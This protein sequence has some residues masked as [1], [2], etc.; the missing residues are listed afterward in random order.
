MKNEQTLVTQFAE[1]S[2]LLEG[3]A[4]RPIEAMTLWE[5]QPAKE[6]VQAFPIGNGRLGGMVFGGIDLERIQLNEE[7]IWV[8]QPQDTTNPDALR[9]L[10]H[11][12][13]LLFEGRNTEAEA[14]AQEHLMSEPLPRNT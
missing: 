12:R 3:K 6:W 8:G 2:V 4:P 1:A 11:L 13:Q 10:P 9:A 5:R 7:T 14:L